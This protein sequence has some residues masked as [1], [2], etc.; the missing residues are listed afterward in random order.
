MGS[1]RG[2]KSD[3]QL[4]T[5]LPTSAQAPVPAVSNARRLWARWFVLVL[6]LNLYLLHS[7]FRRWHYVAPPMT[8]AMAR[9]FFWAVGVNLGFAL[10]LGWFSIRER[11][12]NR[13][14]RTLQLDLVIGLLPF[15][16]GN[17]FIGG[18][19]PRFRIFGT[20]YTVFLL[21]KIILALTWATWNLPDR[22]T[23][24]HAPLFL[25][26]ASFLVFAGF[27]PWIW[28][29]GPPSGDEP[30]Y[31]LL[32]HSLAFDHDFDVGDNYRNYDF[33]EQF[34]PAPPG[35]LRGFVYEQMLAPSISA[36]FHEP[37]MITNYRGQQMLW[38]DV[39]LPLLIAPAYYLDKREGALLMLAL[40]GALGV[41]AIF[42]IALWLGAPNVRAVLTAGIF[43]FT[44][45]FYLY[46]Q[47]VCVEAPGAVAILWAALQFFRYRERPRNRYLLLA[48][49]II[50][51]MPWLIIRFWSLAG[52]L[53][54]VLVAWSLRTEWGRWSRL[55]GKMALL[56]GPSL[57]SLL[58]FALLDKH[59]FNTYLPNA[60][61]LIWGRFL[62]QFW[63]HPM[64]GFLG[65]FLDQS[66]GLMPT[67]PMFV[68]VVAGMIVLFR[69]DRWGFAALF[70]PALG[71]IPFVSR[72]R[73]WMGGW[74]PPARLLVV[75]VMIMVP[76]ASLVLT[77]KTRWIV[78]ALTTWSGLLTVA[79]TVN[80][81]WRMPSLWHLYEK[82]MLAEILHDHMHHHPHFY[83]VLS[84]FP[85]LLRAHPTDLLLAWCWVAVI[86]CSAWLW[87]RTAGPQ[88]GK[89]N[90][91][92][93]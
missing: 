4:E 63:N 39:G 52:P 50:A 49:I 23:I 41:A 26:L 93:S 80:P 74:A 59:L 1:L 33:V 36:I 87:A 72:S 75:G 42:E 55:I 54:L 11:W 89:L 12:D 90:S 25:F 28:L 5:Q 22:K 57:V 85:D 15:L 18:D 73:F 78:V 69:R 70:L 44:A 35:A 14:Q 58:V 31:L 16:M 24:R 21:L 17:F 68:A 88:S 3:L 60:G 91:A 9:I 86:A 46:A 83:S 10:L 67:A 56:G 38:H 47:S 32:A 13:L 19:E 81:Y 27:V 2:G 34:P 37:H 20:I 43:S 76:A 66:F 40:L 8:H 77:R 79:Y 64:L 51:A 48:G 45:P 7:A 61:N 6:L 71:Y 62:P 84:I 53:F 82:S 92:G 29:A 30:A 65:L